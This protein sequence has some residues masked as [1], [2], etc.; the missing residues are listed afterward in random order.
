VAKVV[1]RNPRQGIKRI[2]S[3]PRFRRWLVR[4]ALNELNNTNRILQ[5]LLFVFVFVFVFYIGWNKSMGI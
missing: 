1:L 2:L 3:F 5:S 4:K